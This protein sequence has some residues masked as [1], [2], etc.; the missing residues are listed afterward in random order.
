LNEERTVRKL[1][2]VGGILLAFGPFAMS[3]AGEKKGPPKGQK[4]EQAQPASSKTQPTLLEFGRGKCIP[5]KMM[6]PILEEL[7]KECEG[8]AVIRIVNIDQEKELTEKNKIMMIPTQVFY[9]T[10]GKEVFRHVGFFEKDSVK[11]H[12][13]AVGVK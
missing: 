4:A 1:L 12:L 8:K 10:T 13:Q 7:M 2:I 9:D 6:K 3:Q 5:C 11:V